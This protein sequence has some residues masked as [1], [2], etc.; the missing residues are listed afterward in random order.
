MRN[1]TNQ[2]RPYCSV[3]LEVLVKEEYQQGK[4]AGCQISRQETKYRQARVKKLKELYEKCRPEIKRNWVLPPG[5]TDGRKSIVEE[6]IIGQ[7]ISPF[8]LP[9]FEDQMP[10]REDYYGLEV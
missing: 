6:E 7:D 9:D 1:N 5:E 10:N 4:Q 2:L 3:L 8:D